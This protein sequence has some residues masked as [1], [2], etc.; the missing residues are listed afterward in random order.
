MS[1]LSSHDLLL[2]L[3]ENLSP[4][5]VPRLWDAGID[6]VHLRDRSRLRLSDYEIL[7]Y[8]ADEK[9]AVATINEVD[10]AKLVM[11]K[12]SHSGVA[13]IP[14]GGSRDEQ[15]EYLMAIAN[16]ARATPPPMDVLKNHIVVVDENKF[17]TA[18]WTCAEMPT[19]RIA[20]PSSA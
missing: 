1:N 3:D 16:F 13:V 9:R 6:A 12:R 8:A 4:N 15:Y 19:A 5:I 11:F 17:V 7:R 18:Q 10:F 2:L 20:G 14:S